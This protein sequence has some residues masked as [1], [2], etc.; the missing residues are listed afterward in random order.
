MVRQRANLWSGI[1]TAP[2]AAAVT[3][4]AAAIMVLE[5]HPLVCRTLR[6]FS[7]TCSCTNCSCAIC[8]HLLL[9]LLLAYELS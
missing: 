7:H 2:A 5:T 8:Q 9:L 1:G 6:W 4:T 3:V